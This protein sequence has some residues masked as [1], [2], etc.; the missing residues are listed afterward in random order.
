M[1]TLQHGFTVEPTNDGDLNRLQQRIKKAL[2]TL[3]AG[4]T[5]SQ[6]TDQSKYTVV[7]GQNLQNSKRG[8]DVA[9]ANAVAATS[10]YQHLTGTAATNY[11]SAVGWFDGALVVFLVV[12][13]VTFGHNVASGAPNITYP[14]QLLSGAATAKAANSVIAFRCDMAL[15]RW[16]QVA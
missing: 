3:A 11:I 8:A 6:L 4:A 2:D 15:K 7:G 13:G 12:N 10:E 1:S 5:A 14:L 16:V 9:S